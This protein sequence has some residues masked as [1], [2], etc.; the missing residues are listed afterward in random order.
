L[1]I[2]RSF[3]GRVEV[4]WVAVQITLRRLRPDEGPRRELFSAFLR[5]LADGIKKDVKAVLDA[6]ESETK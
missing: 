6:D 4:F 5:A 2:A 3:R 1:T